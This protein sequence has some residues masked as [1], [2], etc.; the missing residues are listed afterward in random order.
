MEAREPKKNKIYKHTKLI[1]DNKSD[2]RTSTFCQNKYFTRQSVSS[3]D[4]IDD[5]IVMP[6]KRPLGV[7]LNFSNTQ[8]NFMYASQNLVPFKTPKNKKV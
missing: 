8:A 3:E 2:G 1:T 7:N 5:T 4:S 6:V